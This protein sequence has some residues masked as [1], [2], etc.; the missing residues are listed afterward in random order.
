MDYCMSEVNCDFKEFQ[1]LRE[2]MKN[3]NHAVWKKYCFFFA[4]YWTFGWI[5]SVCGQNPI[6]HQEELIWKFDVTTANPLPRNFRVD[7]ALQASGSGQFTI[8][9]LKNLIKT[10]KTHQSLRPS[11]GILINLRRET[12]FY[13]EDRSISLYAK[14]NRANHTLSLQDIERQE[15]LLFN[16][17]QQEQALVIY[18]RNKITPDHIEWEPGLVHFE[19][20][21]NTPTLAADLGWQYAR[22][23]VS[24]HAEPSDEQIEA[25]VDLVKNLAPGT[26]V[27]FYCH[28]GKGRT[29]TFLTLLDILKNAHHDSFETILE[30]QKKL[31][32]KDLKITNSTNKMRIQA[33]KN[34]FRLIQL[35][36]EYIKDQQNGYPK[37]GWTQWRRQSAKAK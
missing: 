16:R 30:R 26:W 18:Q 8:S 28:A 5:T 9:Q 7:K 32:K 21:T 31:G 35:F 10:L 36:H 23:F 22:I 20:I 19:H 24:D 14:N 17:L 1:V 37:H 27:H 4:F 2:S 13:I 11:P 6:L 25:F 29:T 34:R 12:Q 3:F 15:S 33:I